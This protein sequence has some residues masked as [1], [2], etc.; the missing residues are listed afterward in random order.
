MFSG[1]DRMSDTTDYIIGYYCKGP[2]IMKR[3][4]E[5]TKQSLHMQI[6]N[7]CNVNAAFVPTRRA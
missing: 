2:K 4:C 7:L 5:V 3:H 6:I 1:E